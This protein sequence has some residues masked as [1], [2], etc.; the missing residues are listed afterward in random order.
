MS[1]PSKKFPFGAVYLLEPEYT[2]EEIARDVDNMAD[3]GFDLLTLWP[4]ANSWC[5]SDP[6]DFVFTD[7]LKFLD[8]C[9]AR[10]MK[11]IMQ[12]IG[13]NPAQEF[14]PDCLLRP[15]LLLHPLPGSIWANLN[16]PEVQQLARNYFDACIGALA[17]HP[18]VFGW[19]IFNESNFRSTD[20][21]TRRKYQA[22]LEKRYGTIEN[23]NR[24]WQ[25]RFRS[26]DQID[27]TEHRA[28]YSTWSS[29]L[30]PV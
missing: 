27:P 18:A 26:F 28:N 24:Q 13:Q 7:T 2:A 10:G 21:H 11:V 23:L 12:L 14:T 30:P 4:I 5:A 1:L 9:E 8:L 20:E 3:L 15:D 17:H 6:A 29:Q 19:D 16:H 25:R 22:W